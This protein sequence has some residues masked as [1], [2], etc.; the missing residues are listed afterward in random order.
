[1]GTIIYSEYNKKISDAIAALDFSA[2]QRIVQKIDENFGRSTLAITP[3]NLNSRWLEEKGLTDQTKMD[4]LQR[5]AS[6]D[7]SKMFTGTIQL[8]IQGNI[9]RA[10]DMLKDS[11][12]GEKIRNIPKTLVHLHVLSGIL[13]GSRDLTSA[14][15]ICILSKDSASITSIR[16]FDD[17][18]GLPTSENQNYSDFR[19]WQLGLPEADMPFDRSFMSLFLDETLQDHLKQALKAMHMEAQGISAAKRLSMTQKAFKSSLQSDHPVTLTPRNLFFDLFGGQLPFKQYSEEGV[20]P[21][22]IFQHKFPA[23]FKGAIL[24]EK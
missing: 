24:P 23:D 13:K 1:M 3:D 7:E 21:L 20:V 18:R 17:E 16:E 5:A 12:E 11:R 4:V 9:Q 19:L 15:A 8:W 6:D 2:K 14:N 10:Y 22:D